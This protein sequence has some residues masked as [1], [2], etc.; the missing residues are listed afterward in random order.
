MIA[1]GERL[2]LKGPSVGSNP[3]GGTATLRSSPDSIVTQRACSSRVRGRRAA[4]RRCLHLPAPAAPPRT[5][6]GPRRANPYC[7]AISRQRAASSSS[8]VAS[9]PMALA[10]SQ[11]WTNGSTT[12][13]SS[14]NDP[15]SSPSGVVIIRLG[16][17][18]SASTAASW[19]RGRRSRRR[20]GSCQSEWLLWPPRSCP[21][22]Q[23]G[24]EGR[25]ALRSC[26]RRR[27]G[28]TTPDTGTGCPTAA[29]S[30]KCSRAAR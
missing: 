1:A 21:P 7:S 3:T 27:R 10:R 19:T 28:H 23:I 4:A 9:T 15:S 29:G 18:G 30:L 8:M 12:L 26:A 16:T 14:R 2:P 13:T 24:R 25:V 11:P 6:P 5:S 22:G 17:A 20:P